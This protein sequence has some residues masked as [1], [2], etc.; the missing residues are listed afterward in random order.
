[1]IYGDMAS[2]ILSF[3]GLSPWYGTEWKSQELGRAC[4]NFVSNHGIVANNPKRRGS[5]ECMQAVGSTHSR[6][7]AEVMFSESV[8]RHSKGLTI[9][10]RGVGRHH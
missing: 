2:Y 10:R 9:L 8:F 1:M 6:G 4:I 3:R 5:D 7:V